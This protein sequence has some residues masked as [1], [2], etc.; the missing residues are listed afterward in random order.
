MRKKILIFIIVFLLIFLLVFIIWFY[1]LNNIFFAGDNNINQKENFNLSGE[2]GEISEDINL[3]EENNGAEGYFFDET[4]D[5]D[6]DGLIDGEEIKNFSD[7]LGAGDLDADGDGLSN[8]EEINLGT[9]I[10][11]KDTNDDGISDRESLDKN[12]DPVNLDLDSDGLSNF[13]ELDS[14]KTDP[15]N[16]DTDGDGYSDGEEVLGGYNPL[17]EGKL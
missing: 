5:T 7:P 16:P 9:D 4:V 2:P 12:I 3:S 14:S 10:Y 11:K 13:F 17:G 1:F 15:F 6:G 8:K